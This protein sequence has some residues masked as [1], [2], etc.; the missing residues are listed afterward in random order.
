M[1]TDLKTWAV[2]VAERAGTAAGLA[3]VS[4]ISVELADKPVWW[5]LAILPLLELARGWLA[6]HNGEPATASFRKSG[7]DVG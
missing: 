3:A 6:R 2:D 5:A 1:S 4:V 7:R